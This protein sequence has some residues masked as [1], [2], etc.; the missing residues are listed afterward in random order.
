MSLK[1]G[2]QDIA[3]VLKYEPPT[4]LVLNAKEALSRIEAALALDDGPPIGGDAW[5]DCNKRVPVDEGRY[6]VFGNCTND[7]LMCDIAYFSTGI[8]NS[9]YFHK[10][11][12][13][14]HWMELP[15]KPLMRAEEIQRRIKEA[16]K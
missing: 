14:T 16:G 3:K 13:P 1:D 4:T 15:T 8:G 5:I 6:L 7:G 12:Q 10:S 9:G 11:N 2:I